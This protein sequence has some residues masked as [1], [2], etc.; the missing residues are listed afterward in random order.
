MDAEHLQANPDKLNQR[1]DSDDGYRMFSRVSISR[2]CCPFTARALLIVPH[3]NRPSTIIWQ[4]RPRVPDAT[5]VE[6]P[7]ASEAGV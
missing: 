2:A 7:D 6:A 1:D 4:D 5:A 3:R